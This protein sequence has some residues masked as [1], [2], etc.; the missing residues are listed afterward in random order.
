MISPTEM[1][2]RE[3]KLSA[4]T[5]RKLWLAPLAG[6]TDNA[7]RT[8]CKENCADVIVSE[9]VSADGLIYNFQKSIR[10]ARFHEQQR[11]FG[12]QLFGSEPEIM[13]EGVKLIAFSRSPDH[14]RFPF[15][16]IQS[17]A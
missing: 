5:K 7:F 6:F 1:K 12:I 14:I 8:I 17:D 16:A 11:P 2:K 4:L 10:Y 3:I 15:A 9:M 13:K